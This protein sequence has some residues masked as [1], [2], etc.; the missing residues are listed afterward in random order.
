[1]QDVQ[2]VCWMRRYAPLQIVFIPLMS[3]ISYE[4]I[5]P[6]N[7]Y[8]DNVLMDVCTD[9]LLEAICSSMGQLCL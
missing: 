2:L 7:M 6:T 9:I 4:T 3:P 5:V 8:A 1:M